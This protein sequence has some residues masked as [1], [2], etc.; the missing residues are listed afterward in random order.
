MSLKIS[1]V[2]VLITLALLTTADGKKKNRNPSPVSHLVFGKRLF[3]DRA[4]W[5]S[6]LN[7]EIEGYKGMESKRLSL[8]DRGNEKVDNNEL[9]S[10][11][12]MKGN[13]DNVNDYDDRLFN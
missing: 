1:F 11:R 13:R 4:A 5:N 2:L 3:K 10:V 12:P 7:E 6:N 8:Y 9:F